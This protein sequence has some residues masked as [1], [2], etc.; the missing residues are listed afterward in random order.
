M[1]SFFRKRLRQNRWIHNLLESVKR[2]K[3]PGFG[4]M[5]LYDLLTFFVR[6][7]VK[8]AID[9]RAKSLAFSFMLAVFPAIL[10][11]FTLIPYIPVEDFQDTLMNT[12]KQFLPPNTYAAA[13]DTITDIVVTKSGGWLSLSFV[14]AL[15]FATN[16]IDAIMKAFN[17]TYHTLETRSFLKQRLVSLVLVLLIS[18]IVIVAVVLIIVGPDLL[19]YLLDRGWIQDKI[20]YNIIELAKWLIIIAMIFFTVSTVYY[21]APA[22]RQHFQFFSPGSLFA[23][24]LFL[25]TTLGFDVYIN[26]FS[27]FNA[28]YGSIGSLV[29][30]MIWL[31]LN[32]LILLLG[33][34]LNVSIS[35]IR[36]KRE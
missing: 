17:K 34:E 10:F 7:L 8:G 15:T 11:F 31:Y 36:R 33:F 18:L 28:L 21:L 24:V 22:A 5:A 13:E 29:I 4:G 12:I 6:G 2:I 1:E 26:N 14:L 19:R 30:I 20:T 32:S 9:Q 16:G 3:I 25:L 27:R 23:T 35:E